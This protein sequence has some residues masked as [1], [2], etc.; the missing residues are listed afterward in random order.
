MGIERVWI[1]L[2]YSPYA[3]AHAAA[4]V[5][6]L[7]AGLSAL[8]VGVIACRRPRG[9]GLAALALG[10]AVLYFALGTLRVLFVF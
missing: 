2:H 7:L 10:I 5:L 6:G 1:P 4:G 9:R 8:V 3:A